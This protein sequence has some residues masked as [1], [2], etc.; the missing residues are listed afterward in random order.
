MPFTMYNF[1]YVSDI[2]KVIKIDE[3]LV[4]SSEGCMNISTLPKKLVIIGAGVIGLE[5]GSIWNRFGVE[6]V[7]IELLDVIASMTKHT[8]LGF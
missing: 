7:F 1:G 8:Y 6:V 2:P 3:N 5:L 4:L